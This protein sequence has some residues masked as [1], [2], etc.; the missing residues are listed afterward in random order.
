MHDPK[1]IENARIDLEN[2]KGDVSFFDDVYEAVSGAH[3][4]ALTTQWGEYRDLDFE[5]IY[6][7]MIKPTYIFDGRNHLDHQK[8][9]KIGFNVFPLGKAPLRQLG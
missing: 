2:V 8:L 5:R 6:K 9:Y 3:I 7:K 1:A 4:I